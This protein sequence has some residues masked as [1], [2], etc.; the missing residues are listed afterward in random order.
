MVEF[1]SSRVLQRLSIVNLSPKTGTAIAAIPM[2][3][4]LAELLKYDVLSLLNYDDDIRKK[5]IEISIS[6]R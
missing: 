2:A 1:I 3:M 4:A 6:A 5:S